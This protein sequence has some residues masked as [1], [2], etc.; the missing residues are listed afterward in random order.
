MLGVGST[1]S[2]AHPSLSLLSPPNQSPLSS[3][4]PTP[5]PPKKSQPTP[6]PH[7]PSALPPTYKFP[8]T[9]PPLPLPFLSS[10]RNRVFPPP[11]PLH[12]QVKLWEG[13]DG[14]VSR[15]AP[16]MWLAEGYSGPISLGHDGSSSVPGLLQK[17]G[18][19]SLNIYAADDDSRGSRCGMV[20]T[21]LWLVNAIFGRVLCAV[22]R[23]LDALVQSFRWCCA[24]V[25]RD[26]EPRPT[27][28]W[29]PQPGQIFGF[30][31]ICRR[32]RIARP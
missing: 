5:P 8:S 11:P 9:L 19:P 6:L 24:L 13:L 27:M 4:P 18:H 29:L 12:R 17:S 14:A 21:F 25:F 31:F 23:C 2:P 30:W 32:A 7:G 26:F 10:A 3:N 16:Q 20:S 28:R 1:Q 22:R 15:A